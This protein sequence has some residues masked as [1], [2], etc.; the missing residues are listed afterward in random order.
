M[1]EAFALFLPLGLGEDD[2]HD[3]VGIVRLAHEESASKGEVWARTPAE[4]L[5]I[6]ALRRARVEVQATAPP[7]DSE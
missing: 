2:Y 7:T 5:T 3:F 1:Q 4:D 6:R